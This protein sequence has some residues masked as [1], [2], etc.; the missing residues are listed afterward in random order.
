MMFEKVMLGGIDEIRAPIGLS[1]VGD[2]RR[3]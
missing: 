1:W 2:R 3:R